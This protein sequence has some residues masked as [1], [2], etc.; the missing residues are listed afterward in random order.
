[1]KIVN[2]KLSALIRVPPFMTDFSKKVI[3]HSF[4]KEQFNYS[5]LLWMFSTRTVNHKINRLYERGLTA[6]LND[7]TSTLNDRLSKNND[8]TIHVKNIQD[9]MI[10]FDKHIYGLLGT[11]K[12]EVFKK[13]I[14]KY[15]LRSCSVT[16]LPNP[17]TKNTAP[18]R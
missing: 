18:I 17:K 6:L 14:L 1:M 13:R 15:N 11:V 3:F 12:N 2:Q 4:T 8:T 9:L 16:L 7:E 5:P 10:E